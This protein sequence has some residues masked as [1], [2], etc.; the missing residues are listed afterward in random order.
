MSFLEKTIIAS[1]Y[2]SAEHFRDSAF[3]P[4]SI[5]SVAIAT[6]VSTGIAFYIE[7][8]LGV[9]MPAILVV[10]GF[11]TL[12]LFT[13]IRA[14]FKEGYGWCSTK[15]GKGF[16]KLGIY[17]IMVGFTN[18]LALYGPV[19]TY[20]SYEFNHYRWLHYIFANFVIFNYI[21]SN[22]ENFVRLGWED[23]FG[24]IT[25]IAQMFNLQ[26]LKTKKERDERKISK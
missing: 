10:L 1:G 24:V 20:F 18:I 12:E 14:S 6:G 25:R 16:L 23:R 22:L 26:V 21:L 15:F 11:F 7:T 13:G 9:Q 19:E 2:T 3:H 17:A 5:G 4:D 8:F